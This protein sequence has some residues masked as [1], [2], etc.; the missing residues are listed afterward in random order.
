[1][2]TQPQTSA[3][4]STT[5]HGSG[6]AIQAQSTEPATDPIGRPAESSLLSIP[7]LVDRVRPSVVH[8]GTEAILSTT[9]PLSRP[10]T[11]VGTGF[12]IR[13]D[14][15]ILTN[16][17]VVDGA[18]RI[19]VTYEDAV[20]AEALIVGQDPQTDLAVIRIEADNLTPVPLG[21]SSALRVGEPVVAV[22]HALDLLGGP[23]VTSGVVSAVNR[24]LTNVGPYGLTLSDLIQ[25]DAS[26]NPGNSGG[27]LLNL[28]GQ[29]I[30]VN[31]AGAGGAEGIGFAIAIGSAKPIID[32]LISEGSVTRGFIGISATTITPPIA[33]RNS[34]IVNE[35]IYVYAVTADSGAERA[36][37][38]IGDIII[39][40]NSEQVTDIGKLSRILAQYRPGR[41]VAVWYLRPSNTGEIPQ[42]TEV[43]LGTRP[44]R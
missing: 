5:G 42:R 16:N 33:R 32:A 31:S 29:V 7:D 26:I 22:G 17:H 20:V 25:T 24:V 3:P 21:N 6:I 8:I 39:A 23:T 9:S 19:T 40:V 10:R 1:M 43:R 11:G 41:T 34:L 12:I 13:K 44:E 18:Q 28:H 37:L 30:G 14:G 27:P 4:G 15:Y 2:P 35:G 36:G 38:L